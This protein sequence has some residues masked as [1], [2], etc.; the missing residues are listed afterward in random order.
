VGLLMDAILFAILFTIPGL[1][2][3]NIEKRLYTKTKEPESDFIKQYNFF[4]DSVFIYFLGLMAYQVL[5]RLPVF[6]LIKDFELKGIFLSGNNL[7]L[8]ILYFCWSL[9]IC[10]PYA[11]TKKCLITKIFLGVSNNYRSKKN[12]PIE[13]RFSSVWDEIFENEEIPITDDQI[14]VIEK[15]GVIVT[16][17][18][19]K[20]YSPPHLSK[21]EF[22]LEQTSEVKAQLE[23]DNN[24]PD[25]EKLLNV[26]KMEYYDTNSG[27]TIKFIDTTKLVQYLNVMN[28]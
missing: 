18:Y 4:I 27:I 28:S 7:K 11:K 6:N 10:F 9:I 24:L 19:I 21:R 13:K 12:M 14:I 2:V 17:G 22:L 20:S 23:A 5:Y 1:M 16:Q 8:F 26:V 15:D 3:R 25:D